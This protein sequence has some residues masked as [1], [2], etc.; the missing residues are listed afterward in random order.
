MMTELQLPLAQL[1]ELQPPFFQMM[2]L[3]LHIPVDVDDVKKK[4]KKNLFQM[5]CKF[6]RRVEARVVSIFKR[7]KN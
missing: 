1:M 4:T 5:T 3:Q 7:Q 6:F 2:E